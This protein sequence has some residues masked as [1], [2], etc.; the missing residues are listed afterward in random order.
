MTCAAKLGALAAAFGAALVLGLASACG[1]V[2]D[3][4]TDSGVAGR[5]EGM[6]GVRDVEIG[7]RAL[8]TDYYSADLV[9]D[10]EPGSSAEEIAAVLGE[11]AAW[12]KGR[13]DEHSETLYVGSGT[14]EYDDGWLRG[15]PSLIRPDRQPEV[16]LHKARLFL[17]AREALDERVALFGDGTSNQWRVYSD[18]VLATAREVLADPVLA[19]APGLLIE[20]PRSRF[21]SSGPLTPAWV[22]RYE[23]ALTTLPQPAGGTASVMA[24]GSPVDGEDLRARDDRLELIL[25]LQVRERR[26]LPL[27]AANPEGDRFWP[28]VRSQLDV[29]EGMPAGSHLWIWLQYDPIGSDFRKHHDLVDLVVGK[30]VRRIKEPSWNDEAAAYLAR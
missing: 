7:K 22:A 8:D 24:F 10:M 9:V 27:V 20:G 15:G 19:A 23:Q 12:A 5:V 3:L 28:A 11:M 6:A 29:M 25:V 2:T 16:N 4:T 18:D 30:P 26:P 1:T 21:S 14:T 17:A 13:N